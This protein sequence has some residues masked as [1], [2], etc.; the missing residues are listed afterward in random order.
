MVNTFS[1]VCRGNKP[2]PL[3][4]IPEDQPQQELCQIC[5]AGYLQSV[6]PR[7]QA[8]AA[9]D[10]AKDPNDPQPGPSRGHAAAAHQ[11]REGPVDDWTGV[12]FTKIRKQCKFCTDKKTKTFKY[13]C[14]SSKCNHQNVCLIHS[15]LVCKTCWTTTDHGFE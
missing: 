9:T 2:V 11:L 6:P 5:V 14:A 13:T 10:D 4:D 15:K 3:Q 8:A 1:L 12:G 7:A